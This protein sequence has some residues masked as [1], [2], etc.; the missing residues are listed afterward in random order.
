MA[1]E[2][3][4]CSVERRRE[5]ALGSGQWL[6]QVLAFCRLGGRLVRNF[7]GWTRENLVQMAAR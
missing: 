3:C 5:W 4:L 1:G 7:Y 6:D 2:R